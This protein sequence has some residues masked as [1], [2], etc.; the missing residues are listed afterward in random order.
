MPTAPWNCHHPLKTWKDLFTNS[1]YLCTDDSRCLW[2]KACLL[3]KEIF[4]VSKRGRELGAV[5]V[6]RLWEASRLR[7]WRRG[8]R[9][10]VV[11]PSFLGRW[12]SL[13]VLVL[14]DS[15]CGGKNGSLTL[16]LAR[17]QP[18]P[19][20]S[21][22]PLSSSLPPGPQHGNLQEGCVHVCVYVH[23]HM[24]WMIAIRFIVITS[25]KIFLPSLISF[26]INN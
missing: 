1:D 4:C 20:Y 23:A 11:P 13:Q 26:Q 25:F 7:G 21:Y 16:R 15:E 18:S 10:V 12:I 22:P 8:P 14:K 24:C 19:G 9:P 6:G 3:V 2:Y 5:G 17:P